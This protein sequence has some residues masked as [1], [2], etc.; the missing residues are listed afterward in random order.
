MK[1]ET[2]HNVQDL[3]GMMFWMSVWQFLLLYLSHNTHWICTNDEVRVV[4][5][6]DKESG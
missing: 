5:G 6:G 4:V 2:E 3:A 1:D